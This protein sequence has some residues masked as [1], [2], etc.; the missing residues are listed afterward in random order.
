MGCYATDLRH[1]IL[2]DSTG[3]QLLGQSAFMA[4]LMLIFQS[5]NY[6]L[7][8]RWRESNSRA[9]SAIPPLVRGAQPKARSAIKRRSTA[10]RKDWLS[11]ANGA[12][13]TVT[14][15]AERTQRSCPASVIASVGLRWCGVAAKPNGGSHGKVSKEAC[16]G[17][18]PWTNSCRKVFAGSK[19]P[20]DDEADVCTLQAAR[21][22]H[23]GIGSRRH[24]DT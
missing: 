9:K 23:K 13:L 24:W 12:V 22:T 8:R 14:S 21:R 15:G 16:A 19:R 18:A 3:R 6:L 5:L 17:P 2:Q 11:T 7:W 4:K 1:S 10:G 20:Q